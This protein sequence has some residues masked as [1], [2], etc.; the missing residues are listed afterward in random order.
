M[1]RAEGTRLP[2]RMLGRDPPHLND[3]GPVSASLTSDQKQSLGIS[4]CG[5][6]RPNDL[7]FWNADRLLDLTDLC[8]PCFPPAPKRADGISVGKSPTD[9]LIEDR[10]QHDPG[11]PTRVV[12]AS[13][14]LE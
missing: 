3:T 6:H 1:P 9:R 12:G 11:T 10:T 14:S 8:A 4:G 7:A 5:E 13:L 2:D